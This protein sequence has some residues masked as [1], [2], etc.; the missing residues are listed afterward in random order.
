MCYTPQECVEGLS[1][2][3]PFE[4]GKIMSLSIDD[5]R[6][7]PA[8]RKKSRSKLGWVVI[9]IAVVIIL[10]YWACPASAQ[11]A[12]APGVRIADAVM[13]TAL[14]METAMKCAESK[15]KEIRKFCLEL[16]KLEV[17]RGTKVANEAADAAQ[18]ARPVVVASP[19]GYGGYY[20]GYGY[21]QPYN[22]Y[23]GYV[24]PYYQGYSGGYRRYSPPAP[25]PAPGP[26]GDQAVTRPKPLQRWPHQ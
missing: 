24:W 6:Q 3:L 8:P 16:V 11:S 23:G 14:L 17:K 9:A 20:G 12:S 1:S 22:S 4:R 26:T 18:A 15:D 13:P 7:E 25:R 21:V 19:Y 10:F 5:R 2:Q